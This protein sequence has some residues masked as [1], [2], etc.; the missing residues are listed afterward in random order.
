MPF[1]VDS[2]TMALSA[3]CATSTWW[4]TPASTWS[5]TSPACCSRCGRCRTARW[6]RRARRSA[7]RGCTSRSTGCPRATTRRRSS[8]TCSGCCATSARRSRTGARCTPQVD[9]IVTGL[10]D[11][12]PPLDPDEVR[13]ASRPAPVARRRALHLPRLQ[14]VQA[15]VA[16][17]RRVPAR[18]AR[19]RARHPARR[20][21]D[22]GVVRP[23]ARRGQGQGPREDAAGAGQGQLARD[24]APPG[25]PRLRRRQDLRRER[26]GGR[27]APLPR[28]ARERGVH[29]EP[30]ADPA[31]PR[32]G[33]GGAQAQRLR[34]AQ[35]RRQG[36]DGHPRD[37]P[38]RRAA[39]HAA[40]TSSRRWPRPR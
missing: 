35:P 32:E 23:A 22:V 31:G 9:E 18:G 37:L 11:D 40:S 16:R 30:D 10:H 4:C 20:P 13:Q 38:A 29:R 28:A 27:R 8:R 21:G 15:R 36:A 14:G 17:R 7:S 33:Q 39:A 2:L 26:R 6:S 25:V 19:H 1:L 12:P 34:P 5:A 24:R 3:S